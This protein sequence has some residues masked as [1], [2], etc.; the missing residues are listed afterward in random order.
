M[1]PRTVKGIPRPDRK[2]VLTDAFVQQI[3]ATIDSPPTALPISAVFRLRYRHTLMR[4]WVASGPITGEPSGRPAAGGMVIG[5]DGDSKVRSGWP[6]GAW[7]DRC[8]GMSHPLQ[9]R[10]IGQIYQPG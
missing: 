7:R 10:L 9:L 4:W 3:C 5:A 1:P 8:R 2:S 6:D